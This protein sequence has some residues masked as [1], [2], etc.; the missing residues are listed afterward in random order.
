MPSTGK[1]TTLAA[2]G[3]TCAGALYVL[4]SLV[5]SPA[6]SM[7]AEGAATV[8]GVSAPAQLGENNLPKDRRNLF[9]VEQDHHAISSWVMDCRGNPS[10]EGFSLPSEDPGRLIS[11]KAW[12]QSFP[13]LLHKE[14]AL[15]QLSKSISEDRLNLISKVWSWHIFGSI[16]TISSI[17]VGMITTI[18]VSVS[19]TQFGRNPG[20][21]QGLI[22]FAAVL[23]PAVGTAVAG[24]SG[25]YNPKAELIQTARTLASETQLHDQIALVVSGSPCLQTDSDV[26]LSKSIDGWTNRWFEI[27]STPSGDAPYATTDSEPSPDHAIP[28]DAQHTAMNK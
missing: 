27:K 6:H 26:S 11:A 25:F 15:V 2:G 20:N 1:I 28:S 17:I 7:R 3:I 10:L 16:L 23:F 22:R 4:F 13:K 24:I 8:S 9:I 21:T 12:P 19:S 5:V 14:M 18:L